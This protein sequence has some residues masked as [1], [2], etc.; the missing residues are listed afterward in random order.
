MFRLIETAL[1]EVDR[2]V[3][4]TLGEFPADFGVRLPEGKF[5]DTAADLAKRGFVVNDDGCFSLTE[6]GRSQLRPNL[7][8]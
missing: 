6:A 7:D 5:A 4:R 8:S 3:I 2:Y 1:S